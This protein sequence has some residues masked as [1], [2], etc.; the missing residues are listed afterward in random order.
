MT[1][2]SKKYPYPLNKYLIEQNNTYYN[3]NEKRMEDIV[4][5]N[6]YNERKDKVKIKKKIPCICKKCLC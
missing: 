6:L 5:R 1:K 2:A 4:K 3:S